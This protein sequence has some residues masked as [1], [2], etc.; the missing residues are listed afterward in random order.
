[1]ESEYAVIN[2][3]EALLA[4]ATNYYK[5][6]FGPGDGNMFVL[7]P[8]IWRE[9]ECV[10]GMDNYE[11]T[12]PFSEDE[13]K[14]ALFQMEKNKAAGPDGLSIEFYQV[15]WNVV[16]KDIIDLF[17][18]FYIGTLDI[19][20]PNYGII[21]LL[22]KSK[23]A[24]RIQHFRSICLLNC[25]YK[26]FTKCITI[27]LEPLMN[28]I[29]HK[30]ETTF[31][32]GRNIMNNTLALHEILHET[33][34]KRKNGVVLKLDF[35][36]AYDNVHWGFLLKCLK[37]RGFNDTWCKWIEKILC[38]G[39]VAIKI[40]GYIGPYIQSHKGVRQGDPLSPLLFNIVVDCLSK[41]VCLAQQNHIVT[42][43]I[44]HLIPRGV[45]IL[46]YEDD[47]IMCLEDDLLKV[48]N[49]KILLYLFE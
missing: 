9:D 1:L 25:L 45:A 7:D 3:T 39:T 16:K 33:K 5:S 34:R 13:I 2:G 10:N 37:D 29:I 12:K 4:H 15:C 47:T 42:G 40:N 28:K 49:V 44:P 27:R 30:A 31:I 48:R 38:G 6:M 14:E 24:S 22:P 8:S 46:Q 41:M 17:D 21:T 11:L 36:K 18:D 43:I 26:W 35:E 23:E 32:K 20:R 19:K